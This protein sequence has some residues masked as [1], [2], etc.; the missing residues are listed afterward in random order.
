M[1]MFGDKLPQSAK[2]LYRAS[3]NNFQVDKFHGKCDNIAHTLTLCETVHGKVI[4]GYTP[5][6]WSK[7]NQLLKD[8][9]GSSFIFSL[10]NN[11]KFVLDKSKDAIFQH[12]TLGPAFGSGAPDFYITNSSN[13]NKPYAQINISYFN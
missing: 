11:H 9:S 5:L 10:S 1:Q 12:P 6:V 13:T 8:E 2:L 4:G 3:E 7:S